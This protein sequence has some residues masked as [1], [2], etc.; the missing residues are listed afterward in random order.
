MSVEDCKLINIPT[1]AVTAGGLAYIESARDIL[2]S[3]M[4]IY[5]L[6]DVP[7]GEERGVHAHKE[8]Q[9]CM[10]AVHGSFRVTLDD[11]YNKKEVVLDQPDK[12][13]L[14]TPMTWRDLSDFSEGAVCLVLASDFYDEGD[15]IR[16]YETFLSKVR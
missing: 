16:D 9:Q 8:L 15:Y 3:I 11:G 1:A 5:Y 10:I 14:I 6:Y 2:F 13:L 12:G 7:A 4:R